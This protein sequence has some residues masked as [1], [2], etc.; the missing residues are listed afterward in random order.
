MKKYDAIIIGGGV[1]GSSVGYYLT[2]A[3]LKV[4]LVEKGDIAYGTSSGSDGN[5]LIHD[6][7]PGFDTDLAYVSQQLFKK[8]NKDLDRDFEYTQK[9]SMFIIE[10]EQEWD[11]AKDYVDRQVKDGYPMRMLDYDQVHKRE[12]YLA[13]D[14]I[15]GVEIDC[16]ASIN[17]M[18]FSYALCHSAQE[19]GLDIYDHIAVKDVLL[20]SNKSVKSVLLAN[21]EKLSTENI[22]NC[23]GV[24]APKIG[25]M[26]GINIPIKPRQGQL[27]VAEKTF[28]VGERK[29]VEFG[30]MMAKF[31]D[32]NY[33][34]DVDPKLEEMGIAFV[35]E[36]TQSNNFLIGSSRNFSGFDTSVSI[37]VMKGLAQRAVRF[38]PIMKDINVIR[39]Y[40]GLRPYVPDHF[41]I[42]SEVESIPGYYIAAGHEGDGIGLSPITGKIISK[43]IVGENIDL[44]S[45]I[46][47]NFDKLSFNRFN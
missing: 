5:V 38:F 25:K 34:R 26:V 33:K 46:E 39:A 30:Y 10:S 24:W 16:D 23:A 18:E 36:P 31:G 20:D 3:G 8:L 6:K 19:K 2:K 11:V 13:D 40:A 41:P 47:L 14:I 1:I 28:P 43:K 9:G 29:I 21:G 4:A 7:K 12:P 15:G 42:I 45:E 27:L 37:D 17:P 32:E 44:Q 22:I 35:F